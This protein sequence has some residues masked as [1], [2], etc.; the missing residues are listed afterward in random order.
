MNPTLSTAKRVIKAPIGAAR[1]TFPEHRV[2][3]SCDYN[4]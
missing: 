4:Q 1:N 2:I 3:I